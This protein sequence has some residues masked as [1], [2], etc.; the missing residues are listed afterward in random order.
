MIGCWVFGGSNEDDALL[1]VSNIA[2]HVS[3]SVRICTSVLVPPSSDCE[4]L[5]AKQT[6]GVL[7]KIT[8]VPVYTA[9]LS[10]QSQHGSKYST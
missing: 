6:W 9:A 4:V 5:I 3:V 2:L 10:A 1:S 8:Q 7:R